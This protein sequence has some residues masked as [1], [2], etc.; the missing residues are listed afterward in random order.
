M[1]SLFAGCQDEYAGRNAVSGK[2]TIKGEPLK[3]GSIQFVPLDNSG[4]QS[5]G[6][7]KDGVYSIDRKNGLKAGKYLVRVTAGD[8]KTPI[9]VEEA[10]NPG[11]NTN[12]VSH[13]IIP[14]EYGYAS[15]QQVEVKDKVDNVFDIAIPYAVPPPKAKR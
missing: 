8:G 13:D 5:G 14:P 11:G 7:I 1:V 4:T 10:G 2:V 9:N 12:I 15:K 3:D 6:G